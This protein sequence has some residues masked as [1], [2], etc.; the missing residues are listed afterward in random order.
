MSREI[1][2]DSAWILTVEKKRKK[3]ETHLTLQ[4]ISASSKMLNRSILRRVKIDRMLKTQRMTEVSI[5]STTLSLPHTG[6]RRQAVL[7]VP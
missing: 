6:I 4:F 3:R 7:T 2:K 5:F 1:P